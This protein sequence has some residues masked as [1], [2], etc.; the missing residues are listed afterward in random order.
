LNDQPTNQ[1]TN[2]SQRCPRNCSGGLAVTFLE[3]AQ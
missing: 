3:E 1:P 2:P